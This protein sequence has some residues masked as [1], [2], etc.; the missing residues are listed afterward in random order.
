L[1]IHDHS[2][3]LVSIVAESLHEWKEFSNFFF[4]NVFP[5]IKAVVESSKAWDH[6]EDCNGDVEYFL[7][8]FKS[9]VSEETARVFKEIVTE[10]L[11][12]H[13]V[14]RGFVQCFNSSVEEF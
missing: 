5:L 9:P 2:C 1:T 12:T 13:N 3:N 7:Y 14:K 8:S 10:Y 6:L 11:K 4:L